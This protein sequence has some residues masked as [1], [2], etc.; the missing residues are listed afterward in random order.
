M[1]M[2]CPA[3]GRSKGCGRSVFV[4]SSTQQVATVALQE[5]AAGISGYVGKARSQRIQAA[6]GSEIG[7]VIAASP[8]SRRM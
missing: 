1:R 7:I 5:L 2:G 3:G 8:S 4:G 6:S